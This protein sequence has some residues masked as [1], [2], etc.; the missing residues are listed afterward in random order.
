MTQKNTANFYATCQLHATLTWDLTEKV[1]HHKH[2][3]I[4]FQL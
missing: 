3:C 2:S 4:K 1:L